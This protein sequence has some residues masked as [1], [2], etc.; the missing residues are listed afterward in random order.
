MQLAHTLNDCLVSLL[1][2][3]EVEGWVLGGQL[4]EPIAHFVHISLSLGLNGN[5][6]DR[7]WKVHAFQDDLL[8]WITQ[9]LTSDGFL[10]LQKVENSLSEARL[11]LDPTYLSGFAP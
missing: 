7:V 10:G 11:S 4:D 3:R 9:S 1:I 6:D 5:L 8:L 2:S